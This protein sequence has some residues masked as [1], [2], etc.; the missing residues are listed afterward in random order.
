MSFDA[1]LA[2]D[3]ALPLVTAAYAVAANPAQPPALPAGYTRTGLLQADRTFLARAAA[4]PELSSGG[5]L[6]AMAAG[7]SVFGLMGHDAATGTAFVA[8]RGTQDLQ[9][10]VAD[11]DAATA[12]YTE[13]PGFGT[14]HAGFQSVYRAVRDSLGAG[15][16]AACAGCTRLLVTGHSLGGALAV[17]AAPDMLETMPPKLAPEL[18]TF[19]GPKVG[20]AD[21][22]GRFDAAVPSCSRVVNFLD[23][24]PTVPPAPYV[25]VGTGV[26]VDSGGSINPATR[27][28]LDAYRAGLA[29]LDPAAARSLAA[30]W[31]DR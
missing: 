6:R 13:L 8:F 19:G 25:H 22:A 21:F 17:L 16:A 11:F 9:E 20:L 10:W 30:R 14:V 12:A 3:V 5:A 26:T 7:G 1:G 27:H 23:L 2:R 31:P 29:R 18:V 28:G 4:S 24:V 15:L